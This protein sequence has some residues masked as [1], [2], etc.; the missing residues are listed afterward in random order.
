MK[1]LNIVYFTHLGSTGRFVN[2]HL[3]PVLTDSPEPYQGV[4]T[5]RIDSPAPHQPINPNKPPTFSAMHA[6][7]NDFLLVFPCY[8]RNNPATRQLE[9]MVP[10]PV[11]EFISRVEKEGL[12]RIVGGVV[13]GNR[14]FGSDFCNV[15]GQFDYPVLGQVELAG[16]RY[17][18][19][20]ISARLS[21]PAIGKN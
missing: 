13:C 7:T 18:A 10:M 1:I 20:D 16:S 15:D 21:H 12:G 17:D 6:E 14:T 19:E 5:Y 2:R 11:R 9:D 8:G 4:T 3:A